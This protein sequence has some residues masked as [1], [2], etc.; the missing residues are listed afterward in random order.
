[1]M[2]KLL[3]LLC[4]VAMMLSFSACDPEDF[5]HEGSNGLTMSQVIGTWQSTR[6]LIN[7]VETEDTMSITMNAD[8][9]GY[10]NDNENPF[11]FMLV[12][13]QVIITPNGGGD[14]TYTVEL[15]TDTT[16]VLNGDVIPGTD[17]H[18][19][20]KGY[21]TKLI[22]DSGSDSNG[23]SY[24]VTMPEL[25]HSTD[26]S[27]TVWAQFTGIDITADP[28]LFQ[29]ASCG[30]VWCPASESEPLPGTDNTIDCTQSVIQHYGQRFEGTIEHLEPHQ[31]Y[32]VRAWLRLTPESEPILGNYCTFQTNDDGIPVQ[33]DTNWINLENAVAVNDTTMSVTITARFS[34]TPIGIGVVYGTSSNPTISDN[35]YNG[36]EHINMATGQYDSTI[37]SMQENT[38]GSRTVAFFL[39]N[40][41][42]GATY[43]LRGYLLFTDGTPTLYHGEATVTLP[44]E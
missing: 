2:K 28:T 13:M 3:N 44:T 9:S 32:N 17:E 1:M 26:T 24:G 38:D 41:Q 15:I 12:D 43:Y 19:N 25:V 20:F 14:Y 4:M 21:F 42:P 7:N 35:V 5:T 16:M 36:F 40:L 31:N 27:L 29:N 22:T 11:L 39:S 18:T 33:N 34:N 37:Q 8:G 30:F 10:L 23:S 6:I